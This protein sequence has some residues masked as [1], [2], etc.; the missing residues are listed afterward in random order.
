MEIPIEKSYA[1][2]MSDIY[3]FPPRIMGDKA[4]DAGFIEPHPEEKGVWI[5]TRKAM[6]A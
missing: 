6:A 5:F 4:R 1:I 3:F 2:K